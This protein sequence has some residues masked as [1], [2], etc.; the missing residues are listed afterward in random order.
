MLMVR[1]AMEL[2][3]GHM[4]KAA[5]LTRKFLKSSHWLLKVRRLRERAGDQAMGECPPLFTNF[6]YAYV[7]RPRSSGKIRFAATGSCLLAR[8]QIGIGIGRVLLIS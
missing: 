6:P 4:L 5:A 3:A 1:V 2:M 8:D 7:F